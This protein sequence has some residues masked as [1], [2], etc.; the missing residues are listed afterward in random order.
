MN[1]I[2]K[3]KYS[4]QINT[5]I[6]EEFKNLEERIIINKRHAEKINI[7]T[8]VNGRFLSTTMLNIALD[9]I[10]KAVGVKASMSH[11]MTK[12]E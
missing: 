12:I 7:Q 10:I 11:N 9:E 3:K 8:G 2:K 6:I 4:D 5:N 1:K